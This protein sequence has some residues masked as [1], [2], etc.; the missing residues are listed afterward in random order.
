M[1]AETDWRSQPQ[2]WNRLGLSGSW[3]WLKLASVMVPSASAHYASSTRPALL[4]PYCC[5]L[6]TSLELGA[7]RLAAQFVN[8][9]FG[10]GHV[11]VQPL[12]LGALCV[13]EMVRTHGQEPRSPAQVASHHVHDSCAPNA[14]MRALPFAGWF[15]EAD[16]RGLWIA[17]QRRGT[18]RIGRRIAGVESLDRRDNVFVAHDKVSS[19]VDEVGR[20]RERPGLRSV[21]WWRSALSRW[22]D[23]VGTALGSAS[24]CNPFCSSLVRPKGRRRETVTG[25]A[26]LRRC[27]IASVQTTTEG[28]MP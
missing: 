11:P 15:G 27:V 2:Q 17:G 6:G 22:S 3:A 28:R 26:S 25:V 13:I 18:P 4:R 8:F 14:A 23:Q 12:E 5:L 10:Y 1:F 24:G 16:E 9:L 19:T 7:H 20:S 21:E